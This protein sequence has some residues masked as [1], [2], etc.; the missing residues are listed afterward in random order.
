MDFLLYTSHAGA[1]FFKTEYMHKNVH[2]LDFFTHKKLHLMVFFTHKKSNIKD[3]SLKRICLS[4][5]SNWIKRENRKPLVLRGAR[6]TGKTWLV[7]ELAKIQQKHLIE[8]NFESRP[9]LQSLFTSSKMEQVWSNLQVHANTTA[10]RSECLLFLDEIQAAPELLGKLR[11]FYEELP[12]LPVIAAGS[13]LDFVLQD[14]TFS[15]PVGR[16]HYFYIEPLSFYEFLLANKKTT[17]IH[18]LQQFSFN[19]DIPKAIHD[20]L[21][22]Y[23]NEFCLIGGMPEAVSNWLREKSYPLVDEIHTDL[24]T[25]YR[26]DFSKYPTRIA[27]ERLQEVLLAIPKL[28]GNKFTYK[29]VNPNIKANTIANALELLQKARIVHKVQAV[30]GDGIPIGAKPKNR[31]FKTILCDIGL[32]NASLGMSITRLKPLNQ[33]NNGALAE[34]LVGQLLRQNFPHYKD[35]ALFYWLREG[36]SSAEI[37]YLIQHN[38]K[39]IPIEV[40]AGAVGSLRSLHY[41]MYKR[42]LTWA[43]RICSDLP[44]ITPIDLKLNTGE[45]VRYQLISIPFYL[46]EHLPKLLNEL[47][48]QPDAN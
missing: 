31:Y 40:K 41:F 34:Q 39:I 43:V 37:D 13:L 47:I 45:N 23:I 16:I 46:I 36:Q 32:I 44:S 29:Q 5:L 26:D 35:P 1:Y 6:Q 24:L 18:F 17:L 22:Q 15:M 48:I 19:T 10:T 21:I 8:I 7:R 3:N 25:T 14:H 33:N 27:S 28:L 20:D 12:D 9:E 42:G 11:W 2:K 4:E 38:D 30:S